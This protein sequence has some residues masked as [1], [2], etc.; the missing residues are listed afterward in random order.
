M[1]S[2]LY[3]TILID[4]RQ[5]LGSAESEHSL[6]VQRLQVRED[7]TPTSPDQGDEDELERSVKDRLGETAFHD[8]NL[9]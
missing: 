4:P 1:H 6:N 8:L 7:H 2:G 5:E 3:E 9:D